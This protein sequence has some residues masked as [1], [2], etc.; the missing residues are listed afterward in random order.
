MIIRLST[1]SDWQKL[2]QIRLE[3][4]RESPDAFGWSYALAAKLTDDEWSARA[5][6][7]DYPKFFLALENE[8]PVG[9]IGCVIDKQEYCLISM[10]VAPAS[11]NLGVGKQ[12]VDELF[13]HAKES[14]YN[15]I[16][17]MVAPENKS[18]CR[19]YAKCGF[20]FVDVKEPLESNPKI[21]VQKMQVTLFN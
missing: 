4:L 8:K 20:E 5:S 6:G 18:A 9:I 10:W 19:L 14:G 13:L 21:M 15:K 2:K 16:S 12:L 11:R 17:L 1:E 7:K 3:S